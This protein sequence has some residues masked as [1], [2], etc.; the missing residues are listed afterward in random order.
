MGARSDDLE[1]LLIGPRG[2]ADEVTVNMAETDALRT[3]GM[4]SPAGWLRYGPP[5]HRHLRR[6]WRQN[7]AASRRLYLARWAATH[8]PATHGPAAMLPSPARSYAPTSLGVFSGLGIGISGRNLRPG[9]DRQLELLSLLA[10]GTPFQLRLSAAVVA[11]WSD[12][13]PGH[14]QAAARPALTAALTGRLAPVAA[15]WLG[16]NP[17][18]VEAVVHAGDGWGELT[19]AGAGDQRR[20]SAAL[21]ASWLAS[22]WAPGLALVGGHLVLAVQEAAWPRARVLALAQPG[23]DPAV[24]DIRSDAGHW[25]VTTG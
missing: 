19:A 18:L 22:V 10:L 16:M 2:A 13:R 14:D 3:Q 23:A 8:G 17:D 20:L 25:T 1:V 6:Q 21:P 5:G 24:L 7:T 12:G 9:Q 15:A 11:A 4:P